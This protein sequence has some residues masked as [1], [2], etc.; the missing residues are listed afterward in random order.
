MDNPITKDDFDYAFE[1]SKVICEPAR[2]IDTF[3]LTRFEF[4][5]ASELM[6]T[7]GKIRIRAGVVE[8]Q[9]PMII[10]PESY[11]EVA[12]DGFS[13][14]SEQEARRMLER[15]KEN[16]DNLAF[17]RYGFEF[18]KKETREEIVHDSLESVINKLKEEARQA[19]N[20]SLAVLEGVDDTWEVGLLKFTIQMINRSAQVNIHD[21]KRSGLL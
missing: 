1:S 15:L 10:K 14:K 13:E 20:P 17:L 19:A 12:F 7:A 6:D 8:A 3:D 5:M 16:G 11:S 9:K 2:F 4:L 18:K 21:Y